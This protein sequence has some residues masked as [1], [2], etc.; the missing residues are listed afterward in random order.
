MRRAKNTR[1]QNFNNLRG[2]AAEDDGTVTS[3]KNE[4]ARR[5]EARRIAKGWNQSELARRASDYLPKPVKGQRSGGKI[6]RDMVSH[7][8]RGLNLPRP[9]FLPALAKALDC[10]QTDLLPPGGVPSTIGE[11]PAMQM[12]SQPDGRVWLSINRV[13]SMELAMKIASMVQAEDG[14]K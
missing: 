10:E 8:S 12:K 14:K 7:W 5:L 13:V 4:F 6:T 2:H 11:A 1:V 3:L 9:E